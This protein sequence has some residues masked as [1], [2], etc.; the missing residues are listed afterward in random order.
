MR[1]RYQN[2]TT[3]SCDIINPVPHWLRGLETGTNF[4]KQHWVRSHN[5]YQFN[6]NSKQHGCKKNYEKVAMRYKR[7][8]QKWPYTRGGLNENDHTMEFTAT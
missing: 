7:M 1:L 5:Y 3:I 2:M 6:P 8:Q 4:N